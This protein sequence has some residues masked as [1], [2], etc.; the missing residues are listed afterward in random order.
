MEK[1]IQMIVLEKWLKVSK[2]Y[3]GEC[4]TTT[5]TDTDGGKNYYVKGSVSICYL[6]SEGSKYSGS[7]GSET[8]TSPVYDTCTQCTG[9][10]PT[11]DK[12]CEVSCGAVKEYYCGKNEAGTS[13]VTAG[14]IQSE[15]YVCPN[16]CEDGACIKGEEPYRTDGC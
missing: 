10:C 5:C 4:K 11:N 7:E 3:D 9:L 12:D 16:G 14:I 13:A 2:D 1:L 15:T 6:T 8:C